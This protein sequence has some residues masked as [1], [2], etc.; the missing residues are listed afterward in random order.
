MKLRQICFATMGTVITLAFYPIVSYRWYTL[1]KEKKFIRWGILGLLGIIGLIT[2]FFI[3]SSIGPYK[4][5]TFVVAFGFYVAPL[6]C[7]CREIFGC[8][9]TGTR[10]LT[11]PIGKHT[12]RCR[13]CHHATNP[14]F[15]D[16]SRYCPKCRCR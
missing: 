15:L 6:R 9:L 12:L 11:K 4:M 1:T 7:Q 3:P 10:R 13:K 14:A 5:I 8:N 2:T 16:K